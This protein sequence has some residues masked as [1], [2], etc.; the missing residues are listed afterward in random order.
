MNLQTHPSGLRLRQYSLGAAA[1]A[2]G[3]FGVVSQEAGAAILQFSDSGS[4]HRGDNPG[5]GLAHHIINLGDG[6]NLSLNLDYS[7]GTLNIGLPGGGVWDNSGSSG[8]GYYPI[9]TVLAANSAINPTSGSS[10][11]PDIATPVYWG[12]AY[13]GWASAFTDQFIGFRDGAG[14]EGYLKVS[15]DPTAGV[16]SYNG[17]AIEDTG[18]DLMTP[19]GSGGSGG[20]VPE[21]GTLALLAAGAVALARRRRAE[22]LVA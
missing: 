4:I 12:V 11:Y 13:G 8:W 22:K 10:A 16:F 1:L 5:G 2:T 15:W 7:L 14:N 3:A 18:A 6:S 17:G 9:P 19:G 21:P 20:S